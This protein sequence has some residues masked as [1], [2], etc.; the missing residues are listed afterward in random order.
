MRFESIDDGYQVEHWTRQIRMGCWIAIVIS[1]VGAVRV[2]LDWPQSSRW[3]VFVLGAAV[4]AQAGLLV[5]PWARIIRRRYAREL[6]FAWW[7]LELPLLYLFARGDQAALAIFPA[8]A[9][10][11]MVTAAVLY[12]PSAIGTLGALSIGGFLLLVQGQPDAQPTMIAGL[13]A[14]LGAVVA[15]CALTAQSRL[16]QDAR[17]R[18]AEDRVEALLENASDLVLAVCPDGEV[19]YAS[20]SARDLLGRDPSWLTRERIGQMLHPEDLPLAREFMATL[21]AAAPDHAGRIEVR[22]RHGDGTW[23][24]AEAIGVNRLADPN[25][26]AA[27]LSIRDVG[28]RKYMEA[29][30]T[31]QAFTDSLTGLPNRALFHDRVTHAAARNRRDAGR[32][33]LMLIDLDDFKLVN[34]GL[35]HTAGDQL[36]RVIAQRL[37]AQLRP[38][39]TLARLGGDEFAVLVEDLTELEAAEL[40][41]R[42]VR[43]VREPVTLGVRD[44]ICT[45]SIGISVIKAGVHDLGEADELL[46]D[47]DLAM[48]AAK[49]AG[50]DGYAVF[51]PSRHADVLAEAEQRAAL[52][53]ALLEEQFVVHYQP[54]VE[55]PARELIGFEALV[56]WNHPE[57]GLVGP[58]GFI[59]LAEATGLIVPL[60]RWVLD[61]ACR[62]LAAWIA[63]HP[64]AA[65]LRMSVNLSPRQFQHS[66]LVGEV[67]GILE[68]TGVPAD[69]LVLEIT[70]SLLMKDT[71]VTV[72]TLEAL[73]ALGVRLAVDDFGTGYSS[74][75]YLKRFPVD[76]LKIDRSFVDGITADSGD[77]TLAEAVVQLGRTLR[78]QTV[79]EGIETADQWST[80]RELGCEYGQGFLFAR[81]VTAEEIVPLIRARPASPAHPIGE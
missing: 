3:L 62:Q 63:E 20:P 39:D 66:G 17:R 81:P 43:A 42:L 60:G 75:S 34:D 74:L 79:A 7:L 31:R 21:F 33:T 26:R 48:Y 40:A 45:A 68:R 11:I 70:E 2:F 25:L 44:V 56:R 49:A 35:G 46:R 29:E 15:T 72:R 55:L 18:A 59:P 30:L 80:L 77:A 57:D 24:Y 13:L 71:E 14:V 19:T 4:V 52:E 53:R 8:G 51:D 28:A 38:A 10:V 65:T 16:A 36:L 22:L 50:R 1:T 61:Q 54:I 12:P 37:S 58:V 76:I 23:V 5:L 41:D 69:R 67:A 9:I 6:L 47:A 73:K 27:V 32:I 78:L 64:E